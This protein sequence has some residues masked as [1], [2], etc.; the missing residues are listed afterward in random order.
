[1]LAAIALII[2]LAARIYEGSVLRLGQ[3]VRLPRR[4]SSRRGARGDGAA[5]RGVGSAHGDGAP[6]QFR[7]EDGPRPDQPVMK[8]VSEASSGV[9]LRTERCRRGRSPLIR[10]ARAERGQLYRPRER[11]PCFPAAGFERSAASALDDCAAAH[12]GPRPENPPP[13]A[14]PDPAPTR[15]ST[16]PPLRPTPPARRP[17]HGRPAPRR[18]R[19]ADPVAERV[20]VQVRVHGRPFGSGSARRVFR[21]GGC[22]R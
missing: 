17:D 3:R 10:R 7:A 5:A 15:P 4:W 8:N 9:S 1:M 2:P 11:V 13:S 16:D 6:R 20:G 21:A 19:P 14:G 22:G 18:H 12:T